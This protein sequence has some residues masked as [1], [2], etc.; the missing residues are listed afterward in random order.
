M[1]AR[2]KRVFRVEP[3][4]M[5]A[6]DSC[7]AERGQEVFKTQPYG[8]PKNGTMG[9]CYVADA[10]TGRFLGLVLE[11]SLV[12]TGRTVAVTKDRGREVLA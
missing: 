2:N 8:C 12:K 4:G 3:V 11:N 7:V 1:A 10:E 5:D 6:F 9:H